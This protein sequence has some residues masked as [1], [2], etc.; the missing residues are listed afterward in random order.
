[1]SDL[2][3]HKRS[4]VAAPAP[5]PAPAPQPAPEPVPV[6]RFAPAV[7]PGGIAVREVAR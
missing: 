7:G 6:D 4:G 2:G 3:D 1:M 5:A